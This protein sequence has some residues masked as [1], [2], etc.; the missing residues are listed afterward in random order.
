LPRPFADEAIA[1][2]AHAC[3]FALDARSWR[4]TAFACID[5][6]RTG[7]PVA[8]AALAEWLRDRLPDAMRPDALWCVPRWPLNANGK[9]DRRAVGD[10][11]ARALGDAPAAH[12]AF[13][14]ADERQATLLACWE[15]ALGRP[16]N[17]R[18]AT[19][20]ALGGDSLLATRLLAQLR[21]RLGVRIGMA[22]FYR[23]PTLAGLA[24]Q[25]GDLASATQAVGDASVT[26]I[27]EGV[28]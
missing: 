3:G 16:A 12:D 19:F 26:T 9:I 21:E 18:D 25:I 13:V 5:A 17:A 1:A 8:P 11:L 2:A 23:Q 27:E 28:L 24:A 22:A 10:A 6:R 14:P 15:H 7:E 20:F 4:S